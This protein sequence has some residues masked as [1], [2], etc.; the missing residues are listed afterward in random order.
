MKLKKSNPDSMD[1]NKK[2]L[3]GSV[4]DWGWDAESVGSNATSDKSMP[5]VSRYDPTNM[6][7]ITENLADL[8]NDGSDSD[9]ESGIANRKSIIIQGV[10]DQQR[11]KEATGGCNWRQVFTVMALI[12]II[13]GASVTMGYA[14]INNSG[15]IRSEA[16]MAN[17]NIGDGGEGQHLLEIAERVTEACDENKLNEDMSECQ[18]LCNGRMCCFD[19][20]QDGYGCQDDNSKDCA[21][22]AGCEALVEGVPVGAADEDEA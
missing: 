21:V 18:S 3:K 5:I 19:E 17:T 13:V 1:E 9:D 8:V 12:G 6:N 2:A 14:I 11:L 10:K 20:S 4:F 22:Y 16:L 7:R 15:E